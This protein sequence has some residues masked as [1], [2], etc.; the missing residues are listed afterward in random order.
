MFPIRCDA[1]VSK[2]FFFWG[3]CKAEAV[4]HLLHHPKNGYGDDPEVL[5]LCQEHFDMAVAE[6]AEVVADANAEGRFLV[7][8][9]VIKDAGNI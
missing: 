9:S 8:S 1:E 4:K 7:L 6:A 5:L 2:W 3:R